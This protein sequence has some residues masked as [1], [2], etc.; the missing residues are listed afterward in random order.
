MCSIIRVGERLQNVL[1]QIGSNSGSHDNRKPPLTYNGENDVSTLQLFFDPI[2]FTL[3][4]NKHM[5]KMLDEFEFRT[6][7]TTHY[8]VSLP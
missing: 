4:G 8:G 5:H 1:G 2:L 7:R 6:D 3:A